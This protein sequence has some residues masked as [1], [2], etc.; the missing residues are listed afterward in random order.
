MSNADILKKK[1]SIL[2]PPET[3]AIRAQQPAAGESA[4]QQKAGCSSAEHTHTLV[5]IVDSTRVNRSFA[6]HFPVSHVLVAVP[7]LFWS[8]N[9]LEP[10]RA[11][12]RCNGTATQLSV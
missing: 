1:K 5:L 12:Q 2:H 7:L 10:G 9:T 3:P 4:A 8:P 11:P 6:L